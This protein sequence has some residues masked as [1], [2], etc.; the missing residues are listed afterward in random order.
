MRIFILGGG[1]DGII[2]SYLLTV[3]Y[4]IKPHLAL[5]TKYSSVFEKY[6]I[7]YEVG[8]FIDNENIIIELI[9]KIKPTHI[10]N[11]VALSS[12]RECTENPEISHQINALFPIKLSKIISKLNVKLIHFGSILEKESRENCI[13]TK[14]KKYASSFLNNVNSNAKIINLK[15]PNHESPLRDKRFF[16]RE[17]I[18]KLVDNESNEVS[19][20]KLIKLIDG[21]TVR[22]WSW[23]P[24]I[25]NEVISIIIDDKYKINLDN[26]VSNLSLIEFVKIASDKIGLSDL[27]I[28][29]E[30]SGTY[31]QKDIH[32]K[33]ISQSFSHWVGILFSINFDERFNLE[34]WCI[35]V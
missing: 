35:T 20:T 25:M 3:K 19:N 6:S 5:R 16:V 34:K 1:Q 21:K 8:S 31:K 28:E 13:Y 23:A 22:S 24:N 32:T 26:H 17:L 10:I 14:S 11:T 4:G 12:T 27:I 29:C 7:S 2:L 9:N 33:E 18:T 30:R 15:L